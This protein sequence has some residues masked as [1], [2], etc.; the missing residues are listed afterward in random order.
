MLMVLGFISTGFFIIYLFICLVGNNSSVLSP[1]QRS[2]LNPYHKDKLPALSSCMINIL[3]TQVKTNKQTNREH[4][5]LHSI[6]HWQMGR[7]FITE[8]FFQT[9]RQVSG[10]HP[11]PLFAFKYIA[12]FSSQIN[13]CSAQ[14]MGTGSLHVQW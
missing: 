8:N 14:I 6:S 3:P 5:G 11:R 9:Y 12:L 1:T 4:Q 7:M 2:E 10:L 13:S